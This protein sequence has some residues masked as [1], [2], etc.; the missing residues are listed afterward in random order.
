MVQSVKLRRPVSS[1]PMFRPVARATTFWNTPR[2][3]RRA[4]NF[5][6]MRRTASVSWRLGFIASRRFR[7]R[8]HLR[9]GVLRRKAPARRRTLRASCRSSGRC[10]SAC[11]GRIAQAVLDIGQVDARFELH[12]FLRQTVLLAQ[13]FR[14]CFIMAQRSAQTTFFIIP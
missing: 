4:V 14:S 1:R 8:I 2:S 9:R 6:A 3:S 11:D 10:R 13:L 7:I 5:A 12:L